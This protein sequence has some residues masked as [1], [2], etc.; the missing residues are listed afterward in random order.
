MFF[1]IPRSEQRPSILESNKGEDYHLK[2][3][4]H[5]I[6]Q[7]NNSLHNDFITKT[8]RN[9]L[10]Y[11]GDQWNETED[12][13]TFLMDDTG[14][15]RNRMALVM[16]QIR[17]MVEQ[18]RGNAIRM[19]IS[20][21][22]K[23][24]S[25]QVINRREAELGKQLFFTRMAG[26]P[27]NPYS[28]EIKNKTA[29]GDN[30][31]ETRAI[32]EN[33]YT[34]KLVKDMNN[35]AKYIS[36]RND[37]EGKQVKVAEE[38]C[39]SGLGVVSNFEYSGHHVFQTTPSETF[40]FDR[41]AREPDLS[42]AAFM[43]EYSE[44][45]PSE[46]FEQFPDISPDDRTA[47]EAYSTFYTNE[48]QVIRGTNNVSSGK[49]PVFKTFW[50]D[51]EWAEFGYVKDKYG[52]EY[53]T[54]INYTY[55]GETAPRYTEKDL[56][57]SN[58]K[59]AKKLLGDKKSTKTYYDVMRMAIIIP[60][61]ILASVSA[62]KNPEKFKDIVLSWGISPYQDTECIEYSTV[63]YPY[64]CYCWG[65]IDGEIFS[66]I[67]DAIDPQRF[68]NRVW[69]VAENQ[70]N[71][72]GGIGVAYDSS[73]VK[74]PVKTAIDIKHSR[75]VELDARG[76]GMQNAIT[77]YD[78]SVKAGTL[79]LYNIIDAMKVS[80]K[81]TTGVNDAMQG[82]SQ[83][84]DQ[85]VGV[86]QSL[87]QQGSLMQEPFYNGIVNIFK[88]CYQSTCT[89]GKRIYADNE[90]NIAIAV[91]DDGAEVIKVT[92][93]M[94][95]EDFRMFISRENSDDIVKAA[96]NQQLLQFKELLMLDDVRVA[97]LWG[98][99]TTDDVAAALRSYALE[100]QELARMAEKQNA[101]K[102]NQLMAQAKEEQAMNQQIQASDK[103]DEQ[104]KELMK[105]QT[106]LKK[107]G[108]KAV[109]K[110][111][112]NNPSAQKAIMDNFANS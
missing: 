97:N 91:G 107:E 21:R 59:R 10:F 29:I 1:L 112:Q 63:K 58:S 35:L 23:S 83:G 93:E 19:K 49:I 68:I 24:I 100:K 57:K 16:N 33:V 14:Q 2:F 66:P 87:I 95:A 82:Q 5:C 75:P 70:I 80:I 77:N 64:K 31:N 78:A 74:D 84:Q 28:K 17:P 42:D 40:F 46:I 4:R 86:T 11:K 76:R 96:A 30:E 79:G 98:R 110:V 106:E 56:V 81:E 38:L 99:A 88:Q 3:A 34:D 111:A 101:E 39:L 92:E 65:Y 37:F 22:A 104:M 7:S 52:Y 36:A 108:I 50:R 45:F 47:I 60:R 105:H 53:F 18:Y 13:D 62:N 9:K 27:G 25:P 102:E 71:N 109:S 61:E 55:E 26:I 89:V 51:G 85:L 69:S 48:A 20:F 73:M 41:S 8:K 32:F 43:G 103:E 44:M 15:Q 6:G 90:R 94:K 72:A 67:D 12:I 54:K